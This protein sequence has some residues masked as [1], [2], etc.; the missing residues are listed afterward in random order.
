[1]KAQAITKEK[2]RTFVHALYVRKAHALLR[3]KKGECPCDLCE[4]IRVKSA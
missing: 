2:L 4:F 3:K 1:M